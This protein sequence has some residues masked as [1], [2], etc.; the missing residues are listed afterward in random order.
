MATDF[1]EYNVDPVTLGRFIMEDD[2][3][4]REKCGSTR[5]SLCFILQAIGVAGKV[6]GNAVAKAGMQGLYALG[7]A[8]N[9][10]G[11]D[12]KKLDVLANDVFINVLKNTKKVPLMISEENEEAVIVEGLDHARYAVVFDPLDGSSNIEC[13]V[14][15]GSIFGIYHEDEKSVIEM[16][17]V[18]QPG[19][20]MIAAGY[21]LYSSAVVLCM[22][23]G[24]GV[25]MF[26][27]DQDFGEF[28]MTR[29]NWTIPAA[30]KFIYSCNSGNADRW[31]LPPRAFLT[32]TRKCG[33]SYS[34]RYVGSMVSDVHR[35]LLYGGMFMYPADKKNTKGKL[36]LLYECFPMAF[37]VEA[38]GG[39][40]TD[41]RTPILDLKPSDIHERSPIY[42]GCKR[43]MDIIAELFAKHDRGELTEGDCH[44][45]WKGDAEEGAASK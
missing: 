18:M 3:E 7:G 41:G 4:R 12:Q 9:S 44:L 33:K 10:S 32:Y 26:T 27:L 15:V 16:D 1:P 45:A 43:D 29:R 19:R 38:A 30:P 24:S 37:L 14:S 22:S 40:A 35:T 39:V 17:K 20:Q 21:I 25:H 5:V 28:V 11:E 23:T 36:R 8:A 6:I 13:N 34:A 42:L 31:D 2:R